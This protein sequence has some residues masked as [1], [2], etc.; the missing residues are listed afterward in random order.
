MIK[1]TSA[2]WFF[3]RFF[4]TRTAVV[5]LLVRRMMPHKG[6]VAEQVVHFAIARSA[7]EN[8]KAVLVVSAQAKEY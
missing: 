4:V 2:A 5:A 6:A 1:L 3:M 7:R 8:F